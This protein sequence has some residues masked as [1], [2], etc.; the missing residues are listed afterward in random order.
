[1][2]VVLFCAVDAVGEGEAEGCA[3]LVDGVFEGDGH[4]VLFGVSDAVVL[5]FLQVEDLLCLE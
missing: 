4:C 5:A 3:E 2:G 1:V